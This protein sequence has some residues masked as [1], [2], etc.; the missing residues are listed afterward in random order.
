MLNLATKS[1]FRH[2]IHPPEMK[3]DTSSLAIRRFPFAPALIIPL[4]QHLGKPARPVVRPGQEV[5]RGQVIAE[6]DGFMS[7]AMHAPASGIVRKIELN[8]S[9]TG[10][11]VPTVFID[12][13]ANRQDQAKQG[14]VVD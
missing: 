14:Q 5:V 10:R 2:G 3:E 12:N 4:S 9:I 8:P 7:V 11:M 1:T 6:P 13:D